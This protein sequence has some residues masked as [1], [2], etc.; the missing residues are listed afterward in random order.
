MDVG[1]E[2]SWDA[3]RPIVFTSFPP[4]LEIIFKEMV[5][6]SKMQLPALNDGH[7]QDRRLYPAAGLPDGSNNLGYE[8]EY[9]IIHV[10]VE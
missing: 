8:L 2:H 4:A 9:C 1:V 3:E 5:H 6:P 7:W 10:F